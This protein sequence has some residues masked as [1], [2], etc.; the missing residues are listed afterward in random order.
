MQPRSAGRSICEVAVTYRISDEIHETTGIGYH[1]HNWGNVSLPTIVH[2]CYWARERAGPFTVIA[3]DSRRVRFE[4]LDIDIDELTS[5]PVATM[6]RYTCKGRRVSDVR[7]AVR[8]PRAPADQHDRDTSNDHTRT[9]APQPPDRSRLSHREH[10]RASTSAQAHAASQPSTRSPTTL[11][12]SAKTAN[13][14]P[15]RSTSS[16]DTQRLPTIAM[17]A[18][19]KVRRWR[20]ADARSVSNAIV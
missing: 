6:T 1:D 16:S 15:L 9:R 17:R 5:K 14:L 19:S 10:R 3:D 13:P 20:V 12:H 8:H 2:D 18:K 11:H 4:A 7:H